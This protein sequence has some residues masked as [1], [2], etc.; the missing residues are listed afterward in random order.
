MTDLF[1]LPGSA[2]GFVIYAAFASLCL[3][4]LLL[5]FIPA[6]NEWRHPT[7]VAA[8]P[9]TANYSSDIDHFARRL[10]S[11]AMAKLGRGPATGYEEFDLLQN[12]EE[13]QQPTGDVDM[14][15]APKRLIARESIRSAHA[16]QTSQPLFVDG[17]VNVGNAADFSALY[18]VGDIALGEQSHV[19]DW[20]HAEG[21]LHMGANGSAL[22]R[23]SAGQSVELQGGVLFE[24]VHAPSVHFGK[25][26]SAPVTV[27]SA[28]F[29]QSSQLL[30]G[31]FADLPGAVRQTPVLYL[32]RGDCVLAPHS[33]YTK[34]LI[35]TGLLTVSEGTT[36]IGDIKARAGIHMEKSASVRGAV[37][38]EKTIHLGRQAQAWGPLVSETDI[39][40]SSG[41]V[42]GLPDALT[43]VSALNIIAVSGSTVHG[44]VWAHE[45]G[46]VKA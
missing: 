23:I 5:P 32:I 35:V 38:C 9:V 19:R 36:V 14:R 12:F 1:M 15:H 26:V 44:T 3:L 33:L 28:N 16:L 30:P 4:I 41:A 45:I 34:S 18:C 24:R 29:D 13:G 22:R 7:D 2:S 27:D 31:N 10:R 42:V 8:L 6:Y 11:D 40:I 43:T 20:A 25:P 46:M 17:S 37:T 21:A 39:F